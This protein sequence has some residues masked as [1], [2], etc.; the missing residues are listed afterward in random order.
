MKTK[1]QK[2][3]GAVAALICILMIPLLSLLALSVDYGFLLCI[4]TDLQRA[5]DQAALA[6]VRD[7]IPDA[8]GDQDLDKV[9][10]TVREYLKMN[11]GDDFTVLDSDIKIGRYDPDTVYDSVDILDNGIFDTVRV[12]VRHDEMA[13]RSISLYFARLFGRTEADVRAVSTAALQKGRYMGPGT[14]V[15]PFAMDI[16][17]WN[18]LETGEMASIYGDGKVTDEFGKTIPGNWGTVDIGP[19]S[20]ST[21]ELSEQIINGLS[22][23]DIDSLYDQ[24]AISDPTVID[25]HEE[26]S[27]NAESGLSAALEHAVSEVEG[28]NKVMPIFKTVS[29]EGNNAYYE[30]E[31]WAAVTVADAKFQ[32]NKKTY[33]TIQKS[34]LYD[35][36]LRPGNDL[37]DT[38]ETIEGA[39]TSP[40]LIQ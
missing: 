17:V 21:N 18:T 24:N 14:G 9:R 20:N 15:F 28:T 13:N 12:V 37:S 39:F 32:G 19:T 4:R 35:Q 11:M 25:A 22:Q 2:R 33:I 29:G 5:A 3:K 34:Y 16:N 8:F 6:G 1:T 26:M 38:S 7:L 40:V 10:A 31:G 30:I 27:L 36:Y 23:N